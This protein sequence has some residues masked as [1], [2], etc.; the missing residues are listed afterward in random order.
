MVKMTK[1]EISVKNREWREANPNYQK[2]YIIN[3]ENW[4]AKKAAY[5]KKYYNSEGGNR[6]SMIGQW[7]IKGL[8]HD[9]YDDLYNI[10]IN[11]TECMI[12]SKEFKSRRDRCM[13]HDHQTNLYRQ[14][15]CQNC[16]I[17][18]RWQTINIL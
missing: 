11:T 1:E 17:H 8:I 2:D 4:A 15:L 3:H 7:K 13:D 12:C 10:Y 18:D 5:N 9:N 14:I 6:V 16:N